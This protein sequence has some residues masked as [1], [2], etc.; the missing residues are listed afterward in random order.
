MNIYLRNYCLITVKAI[1][2]PIKIRNNAPIILNKINP[3]D[4]LNYKKI[5]LKLLYQSQRMLQHQ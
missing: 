2:A 3:S 4:A 1:N 5:T